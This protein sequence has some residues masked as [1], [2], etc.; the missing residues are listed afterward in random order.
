MSAN[1]VFPGGPR[2]STFR[3][4]EELQH[5][6]LD[7]CVLANARAAKVLATRSAPHA[8]LTGEELTEIVTRSREFIIQTEIVA[9]QMISP[10]R[11]ALTAQVSRSS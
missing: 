1:P 2:D 3:L 4:D 7:S 5:S 9:G 10:L 11:A 8:D 6:L